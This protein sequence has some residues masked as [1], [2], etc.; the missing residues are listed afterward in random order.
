MFFFF[1]ILLALDASLSASL[2]STGSGGRSG[3]AVGP[4]KKEKKCDL[5]HAIVPD[6]PAGIRPISG[7]APKNKMASLGF[8]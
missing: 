5:S 4:E 8:S 6:V 1:K 2:K 3:T 7:P